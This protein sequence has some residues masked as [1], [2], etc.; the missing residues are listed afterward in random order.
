[1]SDVFP[2]YG[3]VLI[4]GQSSRMGRDKSLIDYHGIPQWQHAVRLL[5][6]LVD[7]V[8]LSV[9]Q[10][11]TLDFPH[12]IAD[13]YSDKGPFGAIMTALETY[14][15]TAFLV[16]ATDLPNMTAEQLQNLTNQRNVEKIATAFQGKDKPY[17]EPLATIW[18]PK[19]L[20]Y[21][22]KLYQ[23]HI[24]KL[25]RVFKSN[26]YKTVAIDNH[27]IANINSPQDFNQLNYDQK[28]PF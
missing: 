9:R 11:Q 26:P 24:F 4:G 15:D 12:L 25:Q 2:L 19:A 20:E 16:L 8:F 5:E 3:L 1:M 21:F 28:K 27:F 7:K 13:K 18:E 6:P 22:Q 14:L 17:A 10:G 23:E